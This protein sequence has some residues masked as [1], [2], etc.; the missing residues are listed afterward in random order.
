MTRTDKGIELQRPGGDLLVA[1][2][3]DLEAATRWLAATGL[4]ARPLS[5]R[6][7]DGTDGWMLLGFIYGLAIMKVAGI[8]ASQLFESGAFFDAL[9]LVA[10]TPCFVLIFR[11]MAMARVVLDQNGVRIRRLLRRT[12]LVPW[13]ALRSI[14]EGE[15]ESG[16]RW[17]LPLTF[18]QTETQFTIR[19]GLELFRRGML[20][21]RLRDGI[22]KYGS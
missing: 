11:A 4:D 10:L 6:L 13:S 9:F 15:E 14:E 8:I 12:R 19:C 21:A 17:I 2:V 5:L 20:L 1:Q 7:D 22:S 3:D 18:A 16:G